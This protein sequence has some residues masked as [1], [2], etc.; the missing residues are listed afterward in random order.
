MSG[1]K[2]TF[3]GAAIKARAHEAA[4]RG[5]Q[6]AVEHLL[7][8]A[9]VYTP[10]EY[11]DLVESGLAVSDPATLQGAVSFDGP[12]AIWQHENLDLGHDPGKSAKYLEGPFLAEQDELLRIIGAAINQELG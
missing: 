6:R 3:N 9:L 12:Y 2:M 10:I 11:Y 8:E 7:D 5:L 4:G 1:A